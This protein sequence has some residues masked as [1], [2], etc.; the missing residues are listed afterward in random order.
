MTDETEKKANALSV[1]E[2][3]RKAYKESSDAYDK[4]ADDYWDQL[5]YDDKLM[6][7]YS[8]VK[9]IHKA[10]VEDRGSYRWAI[11]DVFG[12]GFD[13]YSIAYDAGYMDIHNYIYGGIEAEKGEKKE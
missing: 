12:F 7:F 8:V 3:A 11:Y 5:S 2:E 6:A 9:R 13:S 10:E 4:A 1:L